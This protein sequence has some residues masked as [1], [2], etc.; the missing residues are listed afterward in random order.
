MGNNRIVAKPE[1]MVARTHARL[2]AFGR[3]VVWGLQGAGWSTRAIMKV[4]RKTDGTAPTQQAV[5]G[6]IASGKKKAARKWSCEEEHAGGRPL[7]TSRS[8]DKKIKNL[9]FRH[10]GK[11]V[12]TVAFIRKRIRKAIDAEVATNG[13]GRHELEECKRKGRVGKGDVRDQA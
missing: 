9:V 7:K 8:L 1:R 5:A 6:A 4:V 3:G 2:S 12:V 11:I 13:S 10:R